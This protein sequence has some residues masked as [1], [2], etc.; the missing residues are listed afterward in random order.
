MSE[1]TDLKLIE[2]MHR[3]VDGRISRV[4][5][6]LERLSQSANSLKITCNLTAIRQQLFALLADDDAQRIRLEMSG[7]GDVDINT[8]PFVATD[9]QKIWKLAVAR[10]RLDSTDRLLQ[11]KTSR[12]DQY[13]QARQ[14]FS[15]GLADEVLLLNERDELCEGTIS[16]IFIRAIGDK[17]LLTPALHCGLLRG[18]L[19]QEL[20][21][22]GRARETILTLE[23][24]ANAQAIFVGNS[25][26]GLMQASYVD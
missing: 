2:T 13:V 20:L 6:H 4:E 16:N 12:R 25:L 21:D 18:V 5:R 22:H 10:T 9:P 3:G 7:N 15:A 1:P 24:L 14:E 8:Y 26:R 17:Q 23:D 19:R 11:H